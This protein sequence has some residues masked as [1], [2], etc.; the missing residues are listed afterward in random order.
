MKTIEM[1]EL[2]FTITKNFKFFSDIKQ[3]FKNELF[4]FVAILCSLNFILPAQLRV[5]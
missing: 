2:I 5:L 4:D 3:V 1:H